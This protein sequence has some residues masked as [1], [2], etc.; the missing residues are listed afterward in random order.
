MPAEVSGSACC[1]QAQ[2]SESAAAC[3]AALSRVP[4]ELVTSPR[5]PT[6]GN[7]VL[8][9]GEFAIICPP[10]AVSLA[11][12]AACAQLPCGHCEAGTGSAAQEQ[13]RRSLFRLD[14]PGTGTVLAQPCHHV[15]FY[16]SHSNAMC[17]GNYLQ[18]CLRS[19]TGKPHFTDSER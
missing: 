5:P 15:P 6:A 13:V 17:T 9:S 3:M 1:S 19:F 12:P 11:A 18:G 16:Q 14:L 7:S 8:Q 10:P 4:A 2:Q